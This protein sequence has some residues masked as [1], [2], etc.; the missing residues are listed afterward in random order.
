MR[1]RR[2]CTGKHRHKHIDQTGWSQAF[3]LVPAEWFGDQKDIKIA[4]SNGKKKKVTLLNA[5]VLRAESF[6]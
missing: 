5:I 6:A 4:L 3:Y 2:S 1:G